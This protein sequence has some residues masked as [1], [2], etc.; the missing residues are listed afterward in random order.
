MGGQVLQRHWA[1]EAAAAR[2]AQQKQ[3]LEASKK[4]PPR[5]AHV[6]PWACEGRGMESVR[7]RSN[8]SDMIC[9]HCR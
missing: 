5:G 2:Y 4:L 8:K 7:E 1:P 9:L 6:M 3:S